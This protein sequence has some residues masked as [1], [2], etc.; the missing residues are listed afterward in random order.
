MH[1]QTKE[2]SFWAHSHNGGSAKE[3]NIGWRIDYLLV[4]NMDIIKE[5]S[6]LREYT[7]SDH[8]PVKL[9]CKV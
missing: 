2:Y 9:I 5:A 3:H 8:C 4:S 6:I 7:G 1:P